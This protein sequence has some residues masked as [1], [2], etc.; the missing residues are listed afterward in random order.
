M[1]LATGISAGALRASVLHQ[2]RGETPE[3]ARRSALRLARAAADRSD[4][5]LFVSTAL[6]A[7]LVRLASELGFD[8]AR[9]ARFGSFR[10]LRPS[11]ALLRSGPTDA[12]RA[13]AF[14]RLLE[15]ARTAH[16]DFFIL[17][18]VAALDR[19]ERPDA[20]AA[21]LDALYTGIAAEG[22]P[23]ALTEVEEDVREETAPDPGSPRYGVAD[24][25]VGVGAQSSRARLANPPGDGGGPSPDMEIEYLTPPQLPSNTDPFADEASGERLK[26]AHFVVADLRTRSGEHALLGPAASGRE[27]PEPD[28]LVPPAAPTPRQ[29][30]VRAFEEGRTALP[31]GGRPFLAV[32]MRAASS[33]TVAAPFPIVLSALA[34]ALGSDAA[35]VADEGSRRAAWLLPGTDHPTAAFEAIGRAL[36]IATGDAEEVFKTLAV[37][38][39]PNGQPFTD[40]EAFLD[41]AL[42]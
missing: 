5:C 7:T 41:H 31:S 40:A 4:V 35:L 37:S 27:E 16:P 38:L 6:P 14:S 11:S 1:P 28:R 23:F 12:E 2:I 20:F 18:D 22:I 17:D 42:S 25:E 39:A 13:R 15:Q 34:D 9:A 36:R 24:N 8:L 26:H 30:F 19:F 10:L 3:A 33:Q 32:G 29:A 21:A